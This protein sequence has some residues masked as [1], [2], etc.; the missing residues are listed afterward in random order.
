MLPVNARIL[1]GILLLAILSR[2]SAQTVNFPVSARYAG[3]A[4]TTVVQSDAWSGFHNP[5]GLAFLSGPAVGVHYENRFCIPETSIKALTAGIPVKGGT[6]SLQYSLF[7][8]RKYFE[9]R[10]GLAFGKAFGEHFAAGIQINYL[11]T[12]QSMDLGNLYAVV[13]EGGMLAQP[14]EN[15]YIGFHVF[16]PA[17]QHFH[18]YPDQ[19]IPS[20]LQIGIGYR[21][22]ENFF[23]SLEAEKA[24]AEK[25]VI[26]AGFEYEMIRNLYLRL[27]ASTAEIARYAF[28]FGYVFKHFHFDFA[29]SHHQLLGFTPYLTLTYR[30][31][32]GND[33]TK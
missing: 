21:I 9:S 18:P 26:K 27:G 32:K 33:V 20:I 7:G 29:L 5:A 6:L 15:L 3:M 30:R 13:P 1:Y 23:M 11:L 31:E 10:T 4:G 16:N 22:V 24:I 14:L 25:Q 12:H 17:R 19:A 8:Y 28:G 2:L